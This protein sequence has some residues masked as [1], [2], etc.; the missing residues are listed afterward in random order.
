MPRIA[1]ISAPWPLFNRP[2]IQIGS[3][4]AFV[5]ETLPLVHV[6]AYHLYLR[7]AAEIGYDLYREISKRTWLSEPLYAALLYPERLDVIHHFWRRQST[8][9]PFSREADFRR[10]CHGLKRVS[11]RI[12]DEITWETY[13]LVGLSLCFG[14]LTSSLYVIHHIKQRAPL[15]K[16][17]VGGSICS[18]ELGHSLINGFPEIDFVISGEGEIPLVSLIQRLSSPGGRGKQGPI[19][20][21]SDRTKRSK[22]GDKE[23]NQ[24]SQLDQLPVPDYGDYFAGLKSLNPQKFFLPNLPMEISRGCWWQRRMGKQPHNGCAFC[25]LN[26]QWQGYRAKS[27]E[28]VIRELDGLSQKYKVLS[29]SFMDNL[30]PAND[31]KGLFK[32]VALLGK[33]FR[34]F[35]EIRA[36]TSRDELAAMGSAGMREVQVGIEALSSHLLKKLNKGT[37]TIENLEIMKNCE[38]NALP[39]L[40]GN[41]ILNFPGSDQTDVDET[42]ANL[43]FVTPFRPLKGTAF[44]LGYGCPVHRDPASH[45]LKRVNNHPYYSHLFPSHIL[46]G[47]VLII[48]GFHGGVR[49]QQRLWGPVRQ[50]L[51]E[52]KRAYSELHQEPGSE[53]ILSYQD[54]GDFMIIRQRRHGADDMTHRLEGTSRKI[55]LFCQETRSLPQILARFPGFGEETMR[56][57]LEM[58]VDKRLIFKEMDRYLSLAVPITGWK[59]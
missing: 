15:L 51:K 2:S 40:T 26:L 59:I 3:L 16:V 8:G 32:K 37:T 10:I 57:F 1:L 48:Q 18:G 38:A 25:N 42:L 7:V 50:R 30:L 53:P 20:G 17:V 45:G 13:E 49:D 22:V 29:I 34:L 33:E 46:Q 24:V 6:D 52:W 11:D 56:P 9:L 55:Y 27:Q 35:A 54:G 36:T 19:P 12:L 31:L 21:L 47:L 58:M 28:R 41:L 23:F 43:E 4:K 14:Q 44:W 5:K 39:N